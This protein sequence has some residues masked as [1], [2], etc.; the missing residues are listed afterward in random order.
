[1]RR[2]RDEIQAACYGMDVG[3]CLA[4]DARKFR[5]AFPCG[6]P[7]IYETSEQAFLSSMI[8]SMYGTFRVHIDDR[9]SIVTISRHAESKEIHYVDPD[10]AV[11]YDRKPNGTY[12]RNNV[13]Y[14]RPT[15]TGGN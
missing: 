9:C 10:R 4:L 13:E 5:D 2:E 1:M 15:P 3:Q 6:W 12:V 8:G 14:R 7:S 11:Y